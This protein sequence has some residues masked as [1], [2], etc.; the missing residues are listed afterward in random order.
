MVAAFG[1]HLSIGQQSG[2]TL[3]DHVKLSGPAV[4]AAGSKFSG[5]ASAVLT[6]VAC[7]SVQ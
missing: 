6:K 4:L 7:V 2:Y 5:H 1:Q 3:I